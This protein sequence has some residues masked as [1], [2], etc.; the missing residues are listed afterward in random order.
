M[1]TMQSQFLRREVG[2][3]IAEVPIPSV[4]PNATPISREDFKELSSYNWIESS[5]P[6]IMV[7]GLT[8]IEL[9][10]I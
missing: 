9:R 6:T 4:S 7:P 1:I 10:L 8:P 5:T 3:R 2:P